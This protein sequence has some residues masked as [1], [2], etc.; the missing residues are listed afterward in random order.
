MMKIKR[1]KSKIIYF[2]N[3]K[4]IEMTESRVKTLKLY[5]NFQSNFIS[6]KATKFNTIKNY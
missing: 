1:L 6:K 4:K 2:F 3:S 5:Q